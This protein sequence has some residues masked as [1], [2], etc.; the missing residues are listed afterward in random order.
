MSEELLACP[1]CGGES[2][3]RE[4]LISP[5]SAWIT[6]AN[7]ECIVSPETAVML[8]SDAIAAWNTR[9]ELK[10]LSPTTEKERR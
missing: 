8:R 3:L 4:A 2:I 7:G 6:C 1:F 9:H 10:A 5:L